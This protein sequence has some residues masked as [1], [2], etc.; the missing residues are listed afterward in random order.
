MKKPNVGVLV[1]TTCPDAFVDSRELI[2]TDPRVTVLL[3]VLVPLHTLF[4]VVPKAREIVSDERVSGYVKVSGFSN[5]PVKF[6]VLPDHDRLVPAV[7]LVEGV[8]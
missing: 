2:A 8:L 1:A 7:I 3:N 4:V 5:D 6:R